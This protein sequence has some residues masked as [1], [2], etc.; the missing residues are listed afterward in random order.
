MTQPIINQS[1]RGLEKIG[2]DFEGIAF[3]AQFNV[4]RRGFFFLLRSIEMLTEK[5]KPKVNAINLHFSLYRKLGLDNLTAF[6]TRVPMRKE[7]AMAFHDYAF[8]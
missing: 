5:E 2:F 1:E 7:P 3:V 6:F 8:N 4:P